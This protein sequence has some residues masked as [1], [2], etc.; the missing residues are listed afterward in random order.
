MRIAESADQFVS[1]SFCQIES[2][3]R[4]QLG[5]VATI[6]NAP[7]AAALVVTTGMRERHFVVANNAII[8][9]SH[10][11]RAIGSKLHVDGPKPWIIAAQKIGHL[12]GDAR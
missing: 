10:I 8:E 6:D 9:V 11:N 1:R 12:L 5:L 7:D 3:G 4:R 2:P